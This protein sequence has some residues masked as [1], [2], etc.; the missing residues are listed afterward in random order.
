MGFRAV[1]DGGGKGLAR[2]HVRA[3]KLA[4]DHAVQQYLPVRL[5]LQ[6][7]EQP[8]V[9]EVA[10]LVRDGEG[11]HVGQLDEAKLQLILF[12][13][14]QFGVGRRAKQGSHGTC[15]SKET[16]HPVSPL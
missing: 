11:R 3:V 5:R 1:A 8:F 7:D 6:R 13:I 12:Q 2:E 15:K 14:Q 9:F 16:G 10:I 4:V